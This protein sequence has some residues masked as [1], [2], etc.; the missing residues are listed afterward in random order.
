MML[1]IA[2]VEMLG[3]PSVLERD[4]F[5]GREAQQLRRDAT[6]TP[7]LASSSASKVGIEAWHRFGVAF[8]LNRGHSQ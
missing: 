4:V 8:S 1:I 6:R 2:A 7:D 5:D 3:T